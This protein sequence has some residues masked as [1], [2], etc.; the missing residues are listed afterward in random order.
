MNSLLY[1]VCKRTI[2]RGNYPEDMNKRLEAFYEAELISLMEYTELNEINAI[3]N[4]TTTNTIVPFE[5]FCTLP[6][7]FAPPLNSL[8]FSPMSF[9]FVILSLLCC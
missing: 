9:S 8:K 1:K 6:A 4:A 7:V 2:E 3:H 5:L